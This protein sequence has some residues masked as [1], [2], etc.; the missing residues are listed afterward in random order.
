[1]NETRVRVTPAIVAAEAEIKRARQV[2][3]EWAEYR[4]KQEEIIL[5]E[6]ANQGI[7]LP[8]SGS[9][10]VTEKTQIVCSVRRDWVQGCL[11]TFVEK[12]PEQEGVV[13]VL[14]WKPAS[15]ETV[16][17]FLGSHHPGVRDLEECFVEKLIKPSFRVK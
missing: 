7:D 2:E 17:A 4:I 12:Y 3:K 6:L 14:E 1:M 15:K 8:R 16:D 10:N 9:I 11:A 13:V 5:T